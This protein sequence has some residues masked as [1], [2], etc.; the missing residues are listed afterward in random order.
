MIDDNFLEQMMKLGIGMSVIRQMP[1]KM[2]NCMPQLS[3]PQ[4]AANTTPPPLQK[5]DMV[6]YIAI[7]GRQVGPLNDSELKTLLANGILTDD[8]LVW[9][10]QLTQWTPAKC[11]PSI[12]KLMLLSS[13]TKGSAAPAVPEVNP[14]TKEAVVNALAALGYKDAATRKKIDMVL[15]ANANISIEEAIKEVLKLV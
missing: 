1:N 4:T 11:V 10:P 14:Q 7:N 8:T 5:N 12:Q 9:T 6:T 15:S 2:E 13:V 3:K